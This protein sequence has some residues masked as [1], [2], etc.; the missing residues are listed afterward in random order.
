MLLIYLIIST[1]PIDKVLGRGK[2]WF[3]RTTPT[4]ETVVEKLVPTV[5]TSFPRQNTPYKFNMSSRLTKS[6]PQ[7]KLPDLR[8]TPTHWLVW[9]PL[10]PKKAWKLPRSTRPSKLG[11]G[12]LIYLKLRKLDTHFTKHSISITLPQKHATSLQNST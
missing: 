3:L 11:E 1:Y 8:T 7:C 6:I 9:I 2:K 10:E 5:C 4:I 12:V